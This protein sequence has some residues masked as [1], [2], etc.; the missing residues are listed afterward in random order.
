MVQ[1]DLVVLVD[2]GFGLRAKRLGRGLGLRVWS[3]IIGS[4]FWFG[5]ESTRVRAFDRRIKVLGIGGGGGGRES[6]E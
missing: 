2:E 4:I 6:C 3:F 1:W 5:F